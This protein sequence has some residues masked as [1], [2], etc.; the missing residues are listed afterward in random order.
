[1]PSSFRSQPGWLRMR[2]C[3]LR[4]TWLPWCKMLWLLLS[5]G[6]ISPEPVPPI[7]K[8]SLQVQVAEENWVWAA[9][10][11]NGHWNGSIGSNVS[12][13]VL[14]SQC[15]CCSLAVLC[16]CN[17]IYCS[18]GAV[19]GQL[20]P[21]QCWWQVYSTVVGLRQSPGLPQRNW[22]VAVYVRVLY[23]VTYTDIG[24]FNSLLFQDNLVS[25]HQKC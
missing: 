17:C 12:S 19:S 24:P 2:G 9:N 16:I 21:V 5:R 11:E 18:K 13:Y 23:C 15:Q 22:R 25:W 14:K 1:M 4:W 3:L 8:V 20:F 7:R 10:W 6:N